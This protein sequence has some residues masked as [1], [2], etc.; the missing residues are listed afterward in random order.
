MF[1][2]ALS[3]P[4]IH[5]PPFSTRGMMFRV[6]LALLPAAAAY[7]WLFGWGVVVNMLLATG[8]ALLCE[9]IMLALRGR[10]LQPAI[11]DGSAILTALLLAFALPP[12]APW[13]LTTI[14]VA[15]AIV[16]A[17]HLY[18]GLGFNPFNPAM[19]GYVV[20][21]VSFPRELTL[22]L[23][24]AQLAEHTLDPAAT[25]GYVFGATL[26]SG[27]TIDALTAA[28]PLDA[29]KT[30]LGLG[31]TT[32]E[33]MANHPVFGLVGGKGWIWIDLLLL[34]GGVWLIYRRVI[35][36]HIPVATLGSLFAISS[37]FFVLDPQ[38]S[39]SPLFHLFSGAAI[40]GAFF[41]ATDPVTAATSNLGRLW[42]GAG[43]GVL[44]Y[45]IRSWGGFPD[46]VAFA[47]L[48]M[49]MAAPTIDHYTKPRVYGHD[50]SGDA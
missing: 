38:H 29:M 16:V 39:P 13:W 41:I 21:L 9:A 40:L 12:L 4:Y 35:N 30:Q 22:W 46:G 1:K 8:V 25:L 26:P 28:T 3:S 11:T 32:S 17:K 19:I 7:A 31:H 42:Y 48:L 49:N 34:A 5:N 23:L 14:G 2:K 44:I 27:L 50:G 47:V 15:F 18:G 10:P 24:P 45:V 36:W 20:L 6:I 43:I 33:I 37:L